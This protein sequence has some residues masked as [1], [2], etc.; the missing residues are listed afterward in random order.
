MPWRSILR[1]ELP[2]VARIVVVAAVAWELALR[3]G[4]TEPPIYAAFV[5]LL[6]LRD[7]PFGALA[8]SVARLVGVVAGLLIGIGVLA[9]VPPTTT[10]AVAAVLALA[11]L[12]GVFLRIGNVMN[13]G[14]AVSA[15]LV[16]TST[17]TEGYAETRLWETGLGTVTTVVLAPFLFPAN[18]LIVARAELA[19]VA[20]G[21][22]DALRESTALVGRAE[23]D[24]A[25]RAVL[26]RVADDIA[27]LSA[28]LQRLGS[29][30]ASAGKA[31]RWAVVRRPAMRATAE[32]E[33]TRLLAVR[34]AQPL[35]VFAAE[36]L[37]FIERPAFA[38]P[39]LRPDVLDRLVQPLG[40]AMTAALAG[41][42]YIEDL[43]QARAAIAEYLSADHGPV[44]AIVRRPLHR[45]V[46]ELA[47]FA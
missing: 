27:R 42:P 30:L 11:L 47:D 25:R 29:Q 15:L 36:L 4:A 24:D 19:R 32:L 8:L 16:F 39:G 45:M 9:V 7:N 1:A 6:V 38:D 3:L 33:P 14:V 46:Q 44:A 21:L 23:D 2:Q 41:R 26:R 18:P 37:T 20:A 5:P 34:L 31:A 12:A 22:M 13:T 40:R 10:L 28:D 35:E 43:D 17:N